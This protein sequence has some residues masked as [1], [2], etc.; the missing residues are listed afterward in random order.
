MSEGNDS[1]GHIDHRELRDRLRLSRTTNIGPVIYQ[2]LMTRF[3]SGERALAGATELSAKGGRK[4]RPASNED[5]ERELEA[6]ERLGATF[7]ERSDSRYPAALA[8]VDAAPPLLCTMGSLDTLASD[9]IAIVGSRNA[10][11]AGRRMANDLAEQIGA[12]G[13]TLVSGL[14][15]GIDTAVHRGAIASGTTAV[16]AGGLDHIYPEDNIDLA[17]S[18]VD[19]GGALATEMPLGWRARGQDFPRRNRIISGLS[20]AVVVV[21]AARRSGSLITARRAA[22]QGRP[23]YA[24]PGSPLDP[25]AEGA[26]LLIREGAGLITSAADILDD[27][28]PMVAREPDGPPAPRTSEAP[29]GEPETDA[30]VRRLL[31]EALGP[32]PVT[33]D[34]LIRF[35]GQTPGTVHLILLELSLAGRI[36]HHAGQRVS[37]IS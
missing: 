7:V 32:S 26:N 6:V 17:R 18:I 3:G 34:E 24:V 37:L 11:V 33:V 30:D 16:M 31:L 35:T 23:V 20:L 12:A 8:T 36:E 22:D 10:S 19:Q 1:A 5:A 27:I 21:E 9:S 28:A 2:Q 15:R 4:I 25:R 29:A 14:A 13:F